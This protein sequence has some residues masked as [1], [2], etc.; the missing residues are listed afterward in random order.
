MQPCDFGLY[1]WV[2]KKKYALLLGLLIVNSYDSKVEISIKKL[3][4]SEY[5]YYDP[6]YHM[7]IDSILCMSIYKEL[8]SKDYQ[9]DK[10]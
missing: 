4:K 10:L 6:I 5:P 8:I 7:N 3:L 2:F 1:C 9:G